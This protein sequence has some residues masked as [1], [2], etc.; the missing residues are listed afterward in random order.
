MVV[1]PEVEECVVEY[2]VLAAAG[3]V[4]SPSGT[5]ARW[6][7]SRAVDTVVWQKKA[8]GCHNHH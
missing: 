4:S 7:L 1:V 5:S 2:M 8:G 6:W 3:G